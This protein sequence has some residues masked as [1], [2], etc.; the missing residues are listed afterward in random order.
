LLKS[1]K[2]NET[3]NRSCVLDLVDFVTESLNFF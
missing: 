2:V 1:C 3:A